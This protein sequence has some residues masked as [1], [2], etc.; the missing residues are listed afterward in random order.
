MSIIYNINTG[1]CKVFK[2]DSYVTLVAMNDGEH[3]VLEEDKYYFIN[4]NTFQL[5]DT[6]DYVIVGDT[7]RMAQGE[8][9]VSY[10]SKYVVV[11][12]DD[13]YGLIDY[14]GKV[15]IDSIYDDLITIS[16]DLLIAGKNNKYGVIKATGGSITEIKYD[17]VYAYDGYYVVKEEDKIGVLDSKG[18]VLVPINITVDDVEEFNLRFSNRVYITKSL[19]N[20]VID[21]TNLFDNED[22]ITLPGFEDEEYDED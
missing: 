17:F 16:D 18:N 7:N 10:S 1:K 19:D 8:E 15:V 6:A 14:N 2:N 13:K 3:F 12:K 11:T 9:V 20:I 5:I 4:P 21:Y 22:E